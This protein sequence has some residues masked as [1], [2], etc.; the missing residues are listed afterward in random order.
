MQ[1]LCVISPYWLWG[2][3]SF[4]FNNSPREE[5]RQSM[6]TGGLLQVCGVRIFSRTRLVHMSCILYPQHLCNTQGSFI[7]YIS[8]KFVSPRILNTVCQ[9]HKLAG[10]LWHN[11]RILNWKN[12]DGTLSGTVTCNTWGTVWFCLCRRCNQWE[13]FTNIVWIESTICFHNSYGGFQL[14]HFFWANTSDVF[15]I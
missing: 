2:T 9:W 5:A 11:L 1:L 8:L 4:L 15:E 6:N 14:I 3:H 7:V 12:Q 13:M 10:F